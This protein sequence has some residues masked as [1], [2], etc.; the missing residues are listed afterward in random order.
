MNVMFFFT[1]SGNTFTWSDGSSLDY[2]TWAPEHPNHN[3]EENQCV[4]YIFLHMERN[5]DRYRL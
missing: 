1:F 5:L 4:L 2:E 3:D